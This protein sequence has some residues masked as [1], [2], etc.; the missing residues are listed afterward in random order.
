MIN[1]HR[2]LFTTR[3]MSVVALLL[4]AGLTPADAQQN[5]GKPFS[6]RDPRTCSSRK[7]GLT[8]AQARQYIICDHEKVV[9]PNSPKAI[10]TLATDTHAG[11]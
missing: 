6:A 10:L 5:S 9:Q 1:Q 8:A 3:L 7:D 4:G 2:G 11:D